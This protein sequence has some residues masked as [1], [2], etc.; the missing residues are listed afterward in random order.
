MMLPDRYVWLVRSCA[1]LVP[2]LLLVFVLGMDLTAP[3][4]I[5]RVWNFARLTGIR[6]GSVPLEEVFFAV[7]FGSYWSG[8]YE[9]VT[10]HRSQ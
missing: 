1:V 5:E 3:G 7:A 10:W 8:V 4:Y 2:W 9:H 6:L